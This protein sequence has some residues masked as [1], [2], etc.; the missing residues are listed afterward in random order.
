MEDRYE[1]RGKIGQGGLGAVYRGYDVKMSRE[2]A[3]KR[4]SAVAGDPELLEESTS[5]LV[6]EAGALASLQHPNIVTIHDVG[7]DGDGPYVVMELIEGK[8][9]DEAIERAPL[10]WQDFKELA[11]QVQEAL[12]AAQERNLI[13]SDLKPSNLMITWLPSGKFQVKIV[14]FGLA[15]LAH[16]QSKQDLESIDVVFGSIFF[17][18]PEQFERQP[19]DMRSDMY[20]IGCVFYQALAGRYPFDGATGNEVMESHLQHKVVPLKDVRAGIPVWASDWVMWH[21]NRYPQ[22]RPE[23]AREALSLFLQ[24]DR[25][26]KP[27]MTTGVPAVTAGPPDR[28]SVV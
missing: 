16:S 4:I 6:K 18:P 14:D 10:T 11:L 24:N 20:S 22:D 9:L 7:A 21:L 23:S 27:Q 5:Q 28:K 2:V 8:T 1:L 25:V 13:H 19:L 12:I 15:S 3:I 17:M 26:P